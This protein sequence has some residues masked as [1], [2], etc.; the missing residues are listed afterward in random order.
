MIASFG[1]AEVK[2]DGTRTY[3][4]S[5]G[6]IGGLSFDG[7]NYSNFT[8]AGKYYNRFTPSN[9]FRAAEEVY[10]DNI[11]VDN[12][13][14]NTG[15]LDGASG[16][17]V[18]QGSTVGGGVAT[19]SP[20]GLNLPALSGGYRG[21]E[22]IQTGGNVVTSALNSIFGAYQQGSIS[23]Q[24]ALLYAQ[25][26]SGYLSNPSY[27]YQAQHGDDAA[28]LARLKMQAASMINAIRNWIAPV[29]DGGVKND[30][31]TRNPNTQNPT[32]IPVNLP[33][34]ILEILKNLIPAAKTS[35]EQ[36]PS[37]FSFNPTGAGSSAPNTTMR[38]LV[39]LA[40]VAVAGW[41]LYKK[42]M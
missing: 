1:G 20:T 36:P 18:G 2:K 30:P 9:Y 22:G 28:W 27:F 29:E 15:G 17:S 34:G 23:L 14:G 40:V 10:V 39:I 38:N 31:T 4:G 8:G 7:A 25:Q 11:E 3:P 42:Y 16:T 6:L 37:L 5:G 19:G 41:W 32:E 33:P 26:Y 12:P 13:I 24:Q 21:L 35:V